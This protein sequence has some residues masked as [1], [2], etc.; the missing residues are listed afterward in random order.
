MTRI[1][2]KFLNSNDFRT[3]PRGDTGDIKER[4]K[5]SL[6]MSLV[7]TAVLF[8]TPRLQSNITSSQY[9]KM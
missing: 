3:G 6:I 8:G 1:K 2:I 9:L 5:S 7:T 4:D